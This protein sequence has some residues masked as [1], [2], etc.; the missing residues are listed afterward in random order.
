MNI[1]IISDLHLG[2]R[3]YGLKDREHDFYD[4]YLKC[5]QAIV[6]NDCEIAIFA[7]D[8]FDT[9]KPS[10]LA[11]NKFAEGLSIL[12]KHN[13]HVVGIIGNHTQLQVK[14]H[15]EPDRLFEDKYNYD[16]LDE[17]HSYTHNDVCIYG[18]PFYPNH[19]LDQFKKCVSKLNESAQPECKNILVLHQ[20][21]QEFCGFTGAH[22][23]IY[24]LDID[25]FD[26][27]ICGHIHSRIEKELD[28]CLF[29]QPGSIERMNTQ[30]AQNESEV[31]K[32]VTILHISDEISTTFVRIPNFRK[33]FLEEIV[34]S[35][36]LQDLIKGFESIQD[37]IGQIS[38]SIVSCKIYDRTG[39]IDSSIYKDWEQKLSDQTLMFRLSYYNE[40]EGNIAFFD[41]TDEN[42]TP[43]GGLKKAVKDWSDEKKDLAVDLFYKL[44]SKDKEVVESAHITV[45]DFFKKN[46]KS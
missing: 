15:F 24:D 18:L 14:D 20:E 19:S 41:K 29:I 28:N 44:S 13:I 7:G 6:D 40:N 43:L 37:C 42:L 17:T 11:I 5:I 34:V 36:D 25:N 46:Y 27:I 2:Y 10:P 32:G 9:H 8:I 22:M 35:D 1:G 26:C 12:N 30:E 21:F 16:I 4:Q 33:I 39:Q 31:G 23:S 45:D 38:Q 3:Q